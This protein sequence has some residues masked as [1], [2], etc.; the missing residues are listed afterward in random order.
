MSLE[1]KFT[2]Q[3]RKMD[4]LKAKLEEAVEA[5]KAARQMK[6]DAFVA[7]CEKLDVALD[8]LEAALDAQL[9]KQVDTLGEQADR[10]KK[11]FDAALDLAQEQAG[12]EIAKA[13]AAFTLDRATAEAIANESSGIEKIQKGTEEQVVAAKGQCAAAGEN[14]RIVKERREEKRNS[15]KIRA[16]MGVDQ[17]KAKIADR[18]EAVDKASQEMLIQDILDY[19]ERCQELAYAW[20]LESEYA[21]SEALEVIDDYCKKYGKLE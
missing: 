11:D 15:V 9:E 6:R 5:V 14:V 3:G 2:S 4:E 1:E 8:E 16:Q 18:K 19:A 21:V 7:D 12:A 10:Q 13:K 20:A 17:A